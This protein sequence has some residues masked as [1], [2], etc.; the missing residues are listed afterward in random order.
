M[1][2]HVRCLITA[3]GSLEDLANLA[4]HV[5]GIP[6]KT[7]DKEGVNARDR[8]PEW[9]PL[10]F[11]AVLPLP[12]AYSKQP[13]SSHGYHMERQTWGVK[14]G[15]YGEG[16]EDWGFYKDDHEW[17]EVFKGVQGAPGRV[18]RK[19][20]EHV[21]LEYRFQTAWNFPSRIFEALV[22]QNPE[23]RFYAS[24]GGEGPCRGRREGWGVVTEVQEDPI[25]DI[26][27]SWEGYRLV[28]HY[29]WVLGQ[30]RSRSSQKG[31]P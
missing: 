30:E 18:W 12:D 13:Y 7:G 14:W 2:N 26:D 21:L 31:Q 10:S 8:D 20:E 19:I 16:W 1:P 3:A 28:T 15:T 22:K 9:R 27:P 5:E 6:L 24:Y 29:S 11:H 25:A 17:G 4:R 23:L